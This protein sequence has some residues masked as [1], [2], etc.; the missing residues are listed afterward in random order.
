MI[1]LLNNNSLGK[2][3]IN[4]LIKDYIKTT[5][6]SKSQFPIIFPSPKH[7]PLWRRMLDPA[8]IWETLFSLQLKPWGILDFLEFGERTEVLLGPGLVLPPK[9]LQGERSVYMFPHGYLLFLK[10]WG[11]GET[12]SQLFCYYLSGSQQLMFLR[13]PFFSHWLHILL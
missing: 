11:W 10:I 4:N 2:E 5:F 6:G 12:I 9:D 3:Q 7:F 1:F 8:A 13:S